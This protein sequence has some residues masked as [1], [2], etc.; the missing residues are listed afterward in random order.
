MIRSAVVTA[1]LVLALSAPL[2]AAAQAKIEELGRS[3]SAE[4]A[5]AQAAKGNNWM[6]RVSDSYWGFYSRYKKFGVYRHN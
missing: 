6:T 3:W 5:K 4:Q 1:S 2:D